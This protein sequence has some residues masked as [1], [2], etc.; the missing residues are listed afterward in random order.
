M[1]ENTASQ[2]RVAVTRTQAASYPDVA[3]FSPDTA[4]PEYAHGH[5]GPT[6]NPVYSGVRRVLALAGMDAAHV[7]TA[8]WNPLG[9]FVPPGGTVV[10]KPNLVRERH[11]RDPQGW[12]YVLT[13]GS[14]V[15]AVADYAF[16]AVGTAGRVA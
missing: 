11:P 6:T 5:L 10:L 12:Q 9:D 8:R 16:A 14:V 1:P 13:H 2:Y 15:R 4:Y 3:P 7:D